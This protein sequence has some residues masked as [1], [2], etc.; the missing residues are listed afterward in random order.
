MGPQHCFPSHSVMWEH[1]YSV[2]LVQ[3]QSRHCV[4]WEV[5]YVPDEWRKSLPGMGSVLAGSLYVY[6]GALWRPQIPWSSRQC[7][8]QLNA[9]GMFWL[10]LSS[11]MTFKSLFILLSLGYFLILVCVYTLSQ[12]GK[13]GFLLCPNFEHLNVVA[14][15]AVF[16]R[17]LRPHPGTAG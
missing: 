15:N 1:C 12:D 5:D 7:K 9:K 14:W 11:I 4:A 13:K 10:F 16:R 17:I 3:A 8:E 6:F 2:C